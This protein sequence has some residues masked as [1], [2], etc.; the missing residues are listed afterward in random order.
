MA[1]VVVQLLLSGS[2]TKG[3]RDVLR[4]PH[5][6]LVTIGDGLWASGDATPK[7][8]SKEWIFYSYDHTS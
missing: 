2:S 5:T 3:V 6:A 1:E 8:I 7:H 4:V